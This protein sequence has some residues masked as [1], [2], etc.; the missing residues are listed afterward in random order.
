M[1]RMPATSSVTLNKD[2]KVVPEQGKAIGKLTQAVQELTL[3]Y[4]ALSLNQRIGL[5]LRCSHFLLMMASL[6]ECNG[7]DYITKKHSEKQTS[8]QGG[9]FTLHVKGKCTPS[10]AV[11]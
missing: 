4:I 10:T 3:L 2:L 8:H 6:S 7:V 1:V 9:C 5:D 11:S